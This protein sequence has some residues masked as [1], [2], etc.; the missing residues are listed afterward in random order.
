MLNFPS[1]NLEVWCK[2]MKPAFLD[3]K[4]EYLIYVSKRLYA[5]PYSSILIHPSLRAIISVDF[6]Q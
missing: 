1:T 4:F 6:L 2:C 5:S 3:I